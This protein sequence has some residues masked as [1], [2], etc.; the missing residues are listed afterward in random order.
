[1]LALAMTAELHVDPHPLLDLGV[2]E[3]RFEGGLETPEFVFEAMREAAA[4]SSNDAVR[5]A[6]RAMLRHGG[7]K[8]AG[9]GKPASEYLRR[10]G[11]EDK[12]PRINLAVDACN[13]ASLF[14][15]LPISV[16][17]LDRATPPLRVGIADD[18]SYVFNSAGQ[19]IRVRGLLCLH[20]AEGP[21][22]NAVKDAMRTK[23]RA[24]TRRTLS[25]VWG[26]NAI[27]G[28]TAATVAWY[29]ELLERAGA[30]TSDVSIIRSSP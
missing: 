28:R 11:A 5:D 19:E 27:A 16:V 10:A 18:V 30:V 7:Y 1:M 9:R 6:V 17:D 26:T 3:T 12:L 29:R 20:D 21:C 13:A 14:G 24:E 2:F 23:T 15:E 22:A 4:A 8:P 25:L